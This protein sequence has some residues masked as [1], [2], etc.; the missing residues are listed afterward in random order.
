VN[1]IVNRMLGA[2]RLD[3]QTYEEVEHDTEAMPQAVAVVVMAAVAA[4]IGAI[5][6]GGLGG[7]ILGTLGALVGW[8]LWAGVVYLVGTRVIPGDQTRADMGQVLRALAFAQSPGVIRVFGFIPGLGPLIFFVAAIWMLVAMVIAVRQSLD[9][10][11]T[12]RAVGVVLIGFVIYV[13]VF[14]LFFALFGSS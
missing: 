6:E 7:L 14:A 8:V 9:S 2:A 3:V 13:I 12:G 11:S 1:Q 10:E 4:G 5:G